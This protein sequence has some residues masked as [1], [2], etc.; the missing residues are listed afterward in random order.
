MKA[1]IAESA[2]ALQ[3]W[4]CEFRARVGDRI[5][6]LHGQGSPE[7]HAADGSVRWDGLL[8]DISEKKAAELAL[9]ESERRFRSI[10]LDSPAGVALVALDGRYLA[11]NPAFSEIF[12]YSTQELLAA[13]F[14]DLTHPDDRDLSRRNMQRVI[15]GEGRRVRFDK[16]YLH[17]DG[18]TIWAEVTSELVHGPAG[19]PVHFVTHV[20]DVSERKKAEQKVAEQ[21]ALLEIANDAIMVR[22]LEQRILYWNHGCERLY[23]WTA[24]EVVG[25]SWM[26]LGELD[27][28]A[29]AVAREQAL[30]DGGWS[31]EMR[32]V[33][34]DHQEIAVLS[35]W[36]LV[37]DDHGRPKSV[38]VIN[39]DITEKRQLQ[40]QLLRAQR[41]ESIGQ[42]ASGIAH[43]LNNILS[44]IIM[45]VPLLRSEIKKPEIQRL[46]DILESNTRRGAEIVKQILTFARGLKAGKGPIP[47]RP[48]LNEVVAILTETFPRAISI[49]SSVPEDLWMIEGD[50]TQLHQVLM[51]LC[52][53][54]RDAM[55]GGGTLTVGAENLIVDE[56]FARTAPRAKPGP[57]VVWTV[58]DTGSGIPPELLDRIFDPFFTTKEAGKGTGLGL[59]TVIGIVR[60]H[61]GFLKVRSQVGQGTQ[62]HI[63]LPAQPEHPAISVSQP[64]EAPPRGRGETI[65]VVDDEEG[66]RLTT[67]Q[68]LE[69]H[70][71][72]V[73]VAADGK[74]A[75]GIFT[76]YASEIQAVLTDLMMPVMDGVALVGAL[77]KLSPELK[78]L[79]TTGVTETAQTTAVMRLG[80]KAMIRKP[81]AAHVV[82]HKIRAVIDG[83]P[84]AGNGSSRA[85]AG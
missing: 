68:I 16:R 37:R 83:R 76:L 34:K 49:E 17:K 11:V 25:R 24:A 72:R 40:S 43:D 55:P 71:Y 28:A 12:G 79:A 80:V 75:L 39:T 10:F 52:V 74:E 70:G 62:F 33:T 38:F 59:S 56:S 21:A 41:L 44:P 15:E 32:H 50:A 77:R 8:L 82:L 29:S 47:T 65:L 35:R 5:R 7:L 84:S 45:V 36:T 22:D 69:E 14:F 9:A 31:G 18:R 64:A 42:L 48:L 67:R 1:S 81:V 3:P 61:G 20:L 85:S 46:I 66:V 30:A 27:G 57:H 23:G 4:T 26:E 19:E 51:N 13:T 73:L 6:W 60:N 2:Q 63:Y 58:A 78:V 53:N 54:A